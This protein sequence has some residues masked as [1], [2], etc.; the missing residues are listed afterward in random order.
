MTYSDTGTA[1]GASARQI[2]GHPA[3]LSVL[4]IVE[5]WE[6]FSFYGMRALLMLYLTRV[7][8]TE[9]PENMAGFSLLATITGFDRDHAGSAEWQAFASH[10]YGLYSGFVYFTPLIGGWLADRWLGKKAAIIAG[11]AMIAAGHLILT[12]HDY[13]LVALLLVVIGT[14]GVKG[15]IGAQIGDLYH[16]TDDRRERGFA[17]FYVGINI[18][19]AAAPLVCA[20]LAETQGWNAAFDATSVGMVIGLA[21]Y[22]AGARWLP[23]PARPSS[24]LPVGNAMA[25]VPAEAPSRGNWAIL[26]ILSLAACFLWVS[27]E[28]QANSMMRWLVTSPDGIMMGWI[29]AIPPLV[30]LIGTPIL[31]RRWTL[32]AREGR[33][34]APVTKLLTGALII[35]CA[36]LFLPLVA[37]LSGHHAPPI[38]TMLVYL[39]LWEVGDL[40]FSPAAMGLYSRLAPPGRNG[41]AMAIWYLTVFV[42]NIASG[43]LGGLWGVLPPTGYW[44]MIAAITGACLATLFL[45]RHRLRRA[46]AMQID[47]AVATELD[48]REAL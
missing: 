23:S 11:G 43:W 3:G 32:Q 8:L 33:E 14:G 25:G 30:V 37:I 27:Y 35:V 9:H 39:F 28:Q 7:V 48:K 36:Q 16:P 10:I 34:P 26:A 21:L 42:G 12:T 24:D 45:G 18:G 2:L 46:T 6:R 47:K 31:T 40:F 22:V 41:T 13:F 1:K 20:W 44:F 19:A 29:Q 4:F 5:L 15:N 38:A 17:I